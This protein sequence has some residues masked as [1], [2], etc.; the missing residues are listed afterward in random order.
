MGCVN[1]MDKEKRQFAMNRRDFFKLTGLGAGAAFLVPTLL[2]S[3]WTEQWK[4]ED[5]VKFAVAHAQACGATYADATVGPCEV[6]GHSEDFAATSLLESDL[7]GMRICTPFGWRKLVFPRFS[8]DEIR[9]QM[10]LVFDEKR[11]LQME[12][13]HWLAANFSKETVVAHDSSDAS[14]E[15]GLNAAML[16]YGQ[17]LDLPVNGPNSLFCD[18]LLHQ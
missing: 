7:L 5:A 10:Q 14:V 13:N 15:A 8:Q 18:I 11:P 9:A 12:R 4:A 6:F 1:S 3:A 2:A 16:R 17:R